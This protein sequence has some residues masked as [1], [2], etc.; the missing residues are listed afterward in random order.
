M[1]VLPGVPAWLCTRTLPLA[2]TRRA[3]G[4][5]RTRPCPWR[6]A[7]SGTTPRPSPQP[8]SH[9]QISAK[10]YFHYSYFTWEDAWNESFVNSWESGNAY[11]SA[12][13]L[14]KLG[15]Q[16]IY[17]EQWAALASCLTLHNNRTALI[18]SFLQEFCAGH[19]RESRMYAALA[20]RGSTLKY[21]L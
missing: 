3:R 12:T 10:C 16:S 7:A 13:Q 19:L 4:W 20:K 9:R 5:R 8:S 21:D 18:A 11:V 15:A 14:L 17:T 1:I 6:T 2:A